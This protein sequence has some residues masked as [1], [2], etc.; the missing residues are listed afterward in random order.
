MLSVTPQ[1]IVFTASGSEADNMAIRGALKINPEKKHIIISSVEHPAVYKLAKELEAEGYSLTLIPVDHEGQLDLAA[2]EK[3]IDEST[4]LV[5]IMYANNETGVV[6]QIKKISEIAK[7]QKVLFHIDAVQAPG[8][9]KIDL[10]N[11][12]ADFLS[13]SAHKFHGPKGVGAL[14]INK[15]INLPPFIIGGGQERGRRAGTENVS[16][17]VGLGRASELA[18]IDLIKNTSDIQNMRDH[19]ETAIEKKI[20]NVH[21]NGRN[22]IRVPNTSSISFKDIDASILILLLNEINISVS[23]GSACNSGVHKPS[24]VLTAM[25]INEKLAMS[26]V[27]FSLSRFTKEAEIELV[28][29]KLP[30]L[31]EKARLK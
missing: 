10:Q 6:F 9:V 29:D 20:S 22:A 21:I 30:G 19:L 4:A 28:T 5:S 16:G 27:R 17:I 12:Q 23:L 1:E 7:Q 18:S 2:L 11:V 3:T 13:I 14:Y 31:I 8:K 24:R 26:T 25:G 15:K